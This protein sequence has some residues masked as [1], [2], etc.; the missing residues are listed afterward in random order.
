[1]ARIPVDLLTAETRDVLPAASLPAERANADD[2]GGQIGRALQGTGD[3]AQTLALKL[4]QTD[5]RAREFSYEEQFVKLQEQDNQS[6]ASKLQ[7]ISGNADGWMR[8]TSAETEARFSTWI[9]TL[10]PAAQAEYRVKAARFHM[11]RSNQALRDEFSQ[12][13]NNA[14]L[15]LSEEERKSGVQVQQNPAAFEA[16]LQKLEEM[17]DKAPLPEVE[18]KQAK[19]A[20]R[21]R[22]AFTAEI[23]RAQNAPASVLASGVQPGLDGTKTVLRKFEGFITSPRWDVNAWRVGYGSDTITR[24]NGEVVKVEPGMVVTQED[25]ERDLDRRLT[26]EF[27][28]SAVKAVG[29]DTWNKLDGAAQAVLTSLAYNYGAG[30]W[31]GRL[32]GVAEAA[33]TGDRQQLAAAVRALQ[34]DNGSVNQDRRNQE[35]DMVLGGGGA[36]TKASQYLSADQTMRVQ[37]TA[38][39][40]FAQRRR[41][42]AVAQQTQL[43]EQRDRTFIELKEGPSPEATL[44]DARKYG[45]ISS[46]ADIEKAER[47][48]K[49]RRDGEEN[50]VRFSALMQAGRGPQGA[51]PFEKADRD[52]VDAGYSDLVKRGVPAAQAADTIYKATGVPPPSFAKELRGAL[53]SN[54]PA[55]YGAAAGVAS[56]MMADNPNAFA[57][58]EGAKDLENAAIEYDYLT[59]QLGLSTDEA[60]Q[61]ML[62]DA[63]SPDKRDPVKQEQLQAFR[64]DYL[65]QEKVL[66][67][68]TGGL[69]N[70]VFRGTA[71]QGD[72]ANVIARDYRALAEEGYRRSGDPGRAQEYADRQMQKLYGVQRGVITKFPPSKILPALPGAKD[73][74]AWINEQAAAAV[75]NVLGVVV[76]PEQV[77]LMPVDTPIGSTRTAWDNPVTVKRNDSKPGQQSE[78]R[79]VPYQV[80]VLPEGPDQQYLVLPGAFFPDLQ[81][82]ITDKNREILEAA[83]RATPNTDRRFWSLGVGGPE[84]PAPLETPE[85][86]RA[87]EQRALEDINRDAKAREAGK[88][89]MFRAMQENARRLEETRQRATGGANPLR[90]R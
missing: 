71:P 48:I 8:S 54:D 63:R 82:Y 80:H 75:K 83:P 59:K 6:Y 77:Y 22:V 11:A 13:E 29:D 66:S 76:K 49:E 61:R 4:A 64:K 53:A 14:R 32:A 52:A 30:A 20:A 56:N 68:I 24:E 81:Q 31:S 36:A 84:R 43:A 5:Q 60:T 23:T 88:Q 38:E 50:V 45:I 42:V 70:K 3:A 21:N 41:E 62:A 35:A 27:I 46:F 90:T 39:R 34:G 86:V 2:F 85:Q 15:T 17:I 44:R 73:G 9:D 72:A 18:R 19:L 40:A 89:S 67:H 69:F 58:V 16:E 87:R 47:I 79:S 65:S 28:P 7:G 1:M 25:A 74:H 37:E 57:G 55:R 33:K 12:K 51:N 78:F 26:T 10:P